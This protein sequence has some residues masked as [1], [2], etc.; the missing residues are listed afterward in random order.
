MVNVFTFLVGMGVCAD[1]STVTVGFTTKDP[2]FESNVRNC[3]CSLLKSSIL[4]RNGCPVPQFFQWW[5][6]LD[7]LINSTVIFTFHYIPRYMFLFYFAFILTVRWHHY[8]H[9]YVYKYIYIYIISSG[10]VT[11]L[12]QQGLCM[13]VVDILQTMVN[14]VTSVHFSK[15]SSIVKRIV[16]IFINE[17]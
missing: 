6:S 4:R 14:H 11:G 10:K 16:I 12:I 9:T 17:T 1:C 2:R 8:V 13:H 7:R 15:S 5:V 3:V